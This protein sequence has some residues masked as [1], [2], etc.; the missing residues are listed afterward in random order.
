MKNI[1]SFLKKAAIFFVLPA[2]FMFGCMPPPSYYSGRGKK[3]KMQ[4]LKIGLTN[5]FK[6]NSLVL[7]PKGD[8][9][10][11]VGKK[12]KGE[13]TSGEEYK[14]GIYAGERVVIAKQKIYDDVIY[15]K[16]KTGDESLSINGKKY[17]QNFYIEVKSNKFVVINEIELEKYLYGVIGREMSSTWPTESIKAQAVVARTYAL[18]SLR[19]QH[20]KDGF[21]LCD[22]THCQVYDGIDAERPTVSAAIDATKSEIIVHS[23]KIADVFYHS[24]CGGHTESI[25]NVWNV[26]AESVKYLSGRTCHF[27][28]DAPVYK[29]EVFLSYAAITEACKKKNYSVGEINK[30]K[31]RRFT[32]AGRIRELTLFWENGSFV[33]KGDDFRRLFLDKIKS[34]NFEIIE[35]TD[36]IFLKGK[37]LGHG[38][39]LCQYGAKGM[40]DKG[41]NYQ[42]IISYYFPG[43]DIKKWQQVLD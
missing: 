29:W 26:N 20:G 35:K 21:D 32:K 12:L 5:T 41:H 16:G 38:I 19:K 27:C 2:V 6:Q 8:Y 13:L 18:N 17:R 1:K 36:G 39:G 23:K 30:A 3:Y 14:A 34:T 24:C 28:K 4:N 15:L 33:L 7:I 22:T 40:G 37:G 31:V 9:E 10:I 25:T 43:T 42:S 11:Y